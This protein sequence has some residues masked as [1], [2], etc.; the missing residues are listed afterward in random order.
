MDK[1][2]RGRICKRRVGSIEET[3]RDWMRRE[4]GRKEREKLDEER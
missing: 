2:G 4:R 1:D 3:E